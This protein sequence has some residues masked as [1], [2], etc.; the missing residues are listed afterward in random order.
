MGVV[1]DNISWDQETE[2]KPIFT[3]NAL[4][5]IVPSHRFCTYYSNS[6]RFFKEFD[7][8]NKLNLVELMVERTGDFT[9]LSSLPPAFGKICACLGK[10]MDR[11]LKCV[12]SAEE[13]KR[14]R[15]QSRILSK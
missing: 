1:L 14:F 15:Q 12:F 10:P 6:I 7:Y 13:K 11:E 9:Q 3:P 4:G 5:S 2:R 8:G